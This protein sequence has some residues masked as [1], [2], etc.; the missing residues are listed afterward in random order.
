MSFG[1][2][3]IEGVLIIGCAHLDIGSMRNQEPR[4][5][6]I[7]RKRGG[8]ERGESAFLAGIHIRAVFHQRADCIQIASGGGGVQRR[9]GGAVLGAGVDIGA[10]CEQRFHD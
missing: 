3:Q 9:I 10:A 4:H 5:F 2:R 6:H 7:A 8:V 1:E